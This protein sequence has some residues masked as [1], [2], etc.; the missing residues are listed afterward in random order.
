VPPPLSRSALEDTRA[1]PDGDHDGQIAK[2]Y[3]FTLIARVPLSPPTGHVAAGAQ[4]THD[5][6]GAA[7]GPGGGS[8]SHEARGDSGGALRQETGAGATGHVTAP[9]LP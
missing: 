3:L 8:W 2:G 7:P 9:K 5:G 6:P 1:R 4:G